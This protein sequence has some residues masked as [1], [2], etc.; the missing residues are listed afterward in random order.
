MLKFSGM[1]A[2][3]TGGVQAFHYSYTGHYHPQVYNQAA[4]PW[5]LT[6]TTKSVAATTTV[7][8]SKW[9]S[10]Y[11]QYSPI[12]IPYVPANHTDTRYASCITP[13]AHMSSATTKANIFFRIQFAQR[14]GKAT[15]SRVTLQD[16]STDYVA[17][18]GTCPAGTATEQPSFSFRITEYGRIDNGATTMTQTATTTSGVTTITSSTAGYSS[19]TAAVCTL[20]GDEFN[21]LRETDKMGRANPYQD[22]NRGRIA[23]LLI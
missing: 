15:M 13:I 16:A 8:K 7:D 14:G 21:P 20:L 6:A 5:A 12:R 1:V 3:I 10:P 18:T 11:Q 19:A 22:P 17:C 9:Y 4:D 2:A 23:P